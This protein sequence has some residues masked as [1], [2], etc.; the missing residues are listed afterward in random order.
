MIRT[1]ICQ[2]GKRLSI[3]RRDSSS[4][5]SIFPNLGRKDKGKETPR[6]SIDD[7]SIRGTS[8]PNP[9]ILGEGKP[10][11]DKKDKKK[12]KRTDSEGGEAA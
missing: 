8:S 5:S 2:L 11:K 9:S 7:G 10:K 3:G 1:L 6:G 4:T 12:K